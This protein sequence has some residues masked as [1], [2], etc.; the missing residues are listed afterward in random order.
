MASVK[1]HGDSE[2]GNPLPPH[3][4]I[5]PIRS[6]RSIQRAHS[7]A[8]TSARDRKR[9]GR[10]WAFEGGRLQWRVQENTS[11]PT[12]VIKFGLSRGIKPKRKCVRISIDI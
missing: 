8:G 11:S 4:L 12:G 2:R 9:K 6:G 3:G 10:G 7:E 5:F 1:D